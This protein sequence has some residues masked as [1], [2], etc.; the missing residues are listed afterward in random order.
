MTSYEKDKK[1]ADKFLT[2]QS[3]IAR[4]AI[5][6][7]VAPI[8]EDRKRNTDL[9]LRSAVPL[10][11]GEPIRISARVRRHEYLN[12]PSYRGQ[13]TVRRRRPSGVRT[14][15]HKM[16]AGDGDY[17][18]YGFE[19][20]PGSDRL[21][22]WF[23]GNLAVLN[24]HIQR[25]G[26]P[27]KIEHNSDGSSDLAIFELSGMPLEFMVN[28]VGHPAYHFVP[29]PADGCHRWLDAQRQWCGSEPVGQWQVGPL[30]T[31][32]APQINEYPAD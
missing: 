16:R 7:E 4:L 25:G 18:I 2:H 29:P 30:C 12:R 19:S 26:R 1:W 11:N 6:V 22:P 3:E 32:H 24:S 9:V 8:E 17:F 21:S 5:R 31:Q 27:T 13:F 14:E 23:I 28:S 15:W 20:E 10:R